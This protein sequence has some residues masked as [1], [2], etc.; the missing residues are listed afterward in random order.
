[1][2]LLSRNRKELDKWE[3]F[4]L[5]P[6]INSADLV[7]RAY[8][9]GQTNYDKALQTGFFNQFLLEEPFGFVIADMAGD[10]EDF[11]ACTSVRAA[12]GCGDA[13]CPNLAQGTI[14]RIIQTRSNDRDAF[15]F[16]LLRA[17]CFK[18][19]VEP[20]KYQLELSCERLYRSFSRASGN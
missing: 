1:L 19:S 17:E 8:E 14:V 16:P 18:L 7:I 13:S 4:T 9:K 3:R 10:D 12:S 2:K 11:F 20:K 5:V 6:D 15:M